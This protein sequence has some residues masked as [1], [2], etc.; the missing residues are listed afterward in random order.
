MRRDI[1]K[2]LVPILFLTVGPAEAAEVWI[3]ELTVTEG[4]SGAL[5]VVVPVE[6]RR[7]AGGCGR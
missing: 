1:V 3:G 7:C 6:V 4:E 5:E 2:L